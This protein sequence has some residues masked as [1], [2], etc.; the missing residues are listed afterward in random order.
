MTENLLIAV[1]DFPMRMLALL[2]IDE[3]LL[4]TNENW[5]NNFRAL[6]LLVDM[7]QSVEIGLDT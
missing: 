2:S 5:S 3:I 7:A 6:S 1:H 4:P